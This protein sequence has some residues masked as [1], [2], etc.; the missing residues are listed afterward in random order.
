MP[1]CEGGHFCG[2]AWL[3]NFVEAISP[4]FVWLQVYYFV[5]ER[6]YKTV[7]SVAKYV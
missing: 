3:C 5:V 2:C 7:L 4:G 1:S 6:I